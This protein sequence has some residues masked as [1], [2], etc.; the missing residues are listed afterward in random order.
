MSW[1]FSQALMQA[2][3]S[4]HSSPEEVAAFLA[5]NC[6]DGK[7]FA[8]S[9]GN[10]TRQA[11]LC[12]GKTTE[13]YPSFLFGM[14]SRHLTANHGVAVLTWFQGVSRAKTSV[15]PEKG[16]GSPVRVQDYGVRWRALS[17]RYDHNSHMWKTRPTLWGSGLTLSLPT[18]PRWGLMHDGVLWE[19]LM[20]MRRT[21][22]TESGFLPTPVKYDSAATSASNNYHGL[23]W[24]ARQLGDVVRSAV[25]AAKTKW[26]T[27]IKADATQTNLSIKTLQ[28][29]QDGAAFRMLS[30]EVKMQQLAMRKLPTPTVDTAGKKGSPPAFIKITKN[31]MM[32]AD[33]DC[34][35]GAQMNLADVVA[36]V[37]RQ[38]PT[39]QKPWPT[40][41]A[42]GLR[43]GSGVPDDLNARLAFPTPTAKNGLRGGSNSPHDPHKYGKPDNSDFGNLSPVWV[44][45][46][47][48]WVVGWTSMKPL[49]PATVETWL[50]QNNAHSETEMP[51]WWKVDP[52]DIPDSGISKT[53]PNANR[54]I[55]WERKKRIEVLGN[56]QVPAVVAATWILLWNLDTSF[57]ET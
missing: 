39:R 11:Y 20:L 32:Q 37:N 50:L 15:P 23:G 43:G 38:T 3:V 13:S 29:V 44:E 17:T 8:Q 30:R 55:N 24:Q 31:G 12:S 56:G 45:W 33:R 19:R 54:R 53:V 7:Q 51:Q 1:I 49:S 42:T 2:F 10:L 5:E 52:S 36:A 27:P 34:G 40:V 6:W 16:L 18:L 22:E 21:N 48:G 26:A 9:N 47:M 57:T 41:M 28:Q 46:L 35:T 25:H 14:T 4:S